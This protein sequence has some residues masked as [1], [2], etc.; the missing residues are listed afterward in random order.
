V[1]DTCSGECD[2]PSERKRSSQVPSWAPVFGRTRTTR[3]ASKPPVTAT[4]LHGGARVHSSANAPVGVHET[5]SSGVRSSWHSVAVLVSVHPGG[6]AIEPRTLTLG[7]CATWLAIC[8]FVVSSST[9]T[10]EVA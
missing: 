2:A 5:S 8:A 3:S 10:C 9:V 6:G 1:I 4:K 7:W